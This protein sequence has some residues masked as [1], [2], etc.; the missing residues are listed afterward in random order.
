[1]IRKLFKTLGIVALTLVGLVCIILVREAVIAERVA[2]DLIGDGE[3]Y[4]NNWDNGYVDAKGTW[5]IDGGAS[6]TPLNVSDIRCFR[7][8]KLCYV[9]DATIANISGTLDADVTLLD[10]KRWDASTIEYT[11]DA[12]CVTY[13]YV[14]DRATRKLIGRSLKKP[15]APD[16]CGRISSDVRLRFVK[17]LNIVQQLRRERAPNTIAI[18]VATVFVLLMLAWAWRV[19]ARA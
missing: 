16:V 7:D 17:G 13:S 9:A 8:R 1:V 19:I 11:R 3:V 4:V 18:V 14:I 15:D 5:T 2:V 10:I 12:P 6:A